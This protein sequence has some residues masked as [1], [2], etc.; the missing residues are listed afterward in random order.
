MKNNKAIVFAVCA[1]LISGCASM[2]QGANQNLTISTLNDSNVDKTRCSVKNEEGSWD[3]APNS[4]VS[5]HRDGNIMDIHCENDLQTGMSQLE[6]KFD[7]GYLA[8]DL[9]LDACI[10]SCIVDGVSNSFYEYPQ[11]AIVSM[12]EK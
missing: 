12:R 1:A 7:G 8:L 11:S 3:A 9:L 4:A 5:I 6:P 10:I 2:F